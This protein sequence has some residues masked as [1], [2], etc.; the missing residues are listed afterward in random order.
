M[1][2]PCKICIN[3]F[4]Y[5]PTCEAKPVPHKRQGFCS[6]KC[7][8]ISNIMQKFGCHIASAEETAQ[9]LA[10]YNIDEIELQPNIKDYYNSI[11]RDAKPKRIRRQKAEVVPEENVEVVIENAEDAATSIEK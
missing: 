9:A 10:Q 1:L 3:Q 11:V 5:C 8:E 4:D 7:Y 2:K 6:E